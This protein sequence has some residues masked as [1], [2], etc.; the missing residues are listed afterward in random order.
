MKTRQSAV[1]VVELVQLAGVAGQRACQRSKSRLGVQVPN[2]FILRAGDDPS[3]LSHLVG[4]RTDLK[5][6]LSLLLLAKAP[7]EDGRHTLTIRPGE[8]AGL[9]GGSPY[10]P[11]WARTVRDSL[12]RLADLSAIE[13]TRPNGA[14]RPADIRLLDWNAANPGDYQKPRSRYLTLPNGFWTNGWQAFLTS[15]ALAMLLISI[16]QHNWANPRLESGADPSRNPFW[17]S[18]RSA[19]TLYGLHPDTRSRGWKELEGVHLVTKGRQLIPSSLDPQRKRNTYKL[20]L[21][22]LQRPPFARAEP[23]TDV[24]AP[25]TDPFDQ[26]PKLQDPFND[27]PEDP[28]GLNANVL[29]ATTDLVTLELQDRRVAFK[30]EEVAQVPTQEPGDGRTYYVTAKGKVV[31]YDARLKS[32]TVQ[33]LDEFA[34]DGR[35]AG[36]VRDAILHHLAGGGHVRILD[37]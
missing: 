7:D 34:D 5:V 36:P 14:A 20:N 21:S 4:Q 26:W 17:I 1:D 16:H 22:R 6:Y 3:P 30:G 12:T 2:S 28:P 15:R 9:F 18:P 11:K 23:A 29:D 8:M 31:T 13:V 19:D 32:M 24:A 10:D 35:V 25:P 27:A 33:E 37:I